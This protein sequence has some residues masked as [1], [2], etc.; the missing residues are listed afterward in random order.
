MVAYFAGLQIFLFPCFCIAFVPHCNGHINGLKYITDEISFYEIGIRRDRGKGSSGWL[1][2]KLGSCCRI[3]TLNLW[4]SRFSINAPWWYL[5]FYTMMSP[6][7]TQNSKSKVVFA[8]PA[9]TV[10]TV[11]KYV[12]PEHVPIQ[13]GGLSVDY[14][15]CNPQFTIDD[16]AAVVT[17]KPTTKQ[18]VEIIVN[19]EKL[20]EGRETIVC[21]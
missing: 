17:V 11:F 18:T 10:E 6:F 4:Q 13:Y 3:I 15:D 16:P 5:A 2:N 9:R 14:C 20:R 7:M 21:W 12:S 1:Q 19:E 8:S